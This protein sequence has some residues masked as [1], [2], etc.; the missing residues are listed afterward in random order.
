MRCNQSR[1]DDRAPQWL[2]YSWEEGKNTTA[3]WDEV[4]RVPG[5]SRPWRMESGWSTDED[6]GARSQPWCAVARVQQEQVPHSGV[7]QVQP[8]VAA[9]VQLHSSVLCCGCCS[10][11]A[12]PAQP[13]CSALRECSR[14]FTPACC[15]AGAAA[16]CCHS[17]SFTPARC[18]AGAAA[19]RAAWSALRSSR[20]RCPGTFFPAQSGRAPPA[21]GHR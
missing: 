16:A 3:R 15:G 6:G 18:G 8:Q 20:S 4:S 7:L 5:D 13:H 11:L 19:A 21:A 9:T 1:K 2:V 14:S 10:S 17:H 12:A